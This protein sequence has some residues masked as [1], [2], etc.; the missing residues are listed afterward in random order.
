[1]TYI[2]DNMPIERAYELGYFH[3]KFDSKAISEDVNFTYG[4]Y[5]LT[6]DTKILYY[7]GAFGVF[8]DGH[9]SAIV[10]AINFY[11][12]SGIKVL[13]VI[14]PCNSD[15]TASKYGAYSPMAANKQ[16]YE[17]IK[18]CLPEGV[19]IDLNCMLNYIEDVN[20]TELLLRFVKV[21]GFEMKDFTHK[22]TLVFGKD[23]QQWEALKNYSDEIDTFAAPD[24]TGMSSSNL[25]AI[26]YPNDIVK[27][28]CV[29]R[30]HTI[31]EYRH[32]RSC[33]ADQYKTI[34]PQLISQ[35]IA[36]VDHF[37]NHHKTN[38]PVVTI[39]KDYAGILPYYPLS[40]TWINPFEQGGFSD[41]KLKHLRKSL[42]VD[43]DTFTGSTRDYILSLGHEFVAM[44]EYSCE[45][46]EVL[47]IDDFRKD[48]FRYPFTDISYRCS[49]QAFDSKMHHK[50]NNFKFLMKGK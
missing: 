45:E 10:S 41:N 17:S 18:N 14:A 21:H 49:M 38:L 5:S 13:A 23:R 25:K 27:K 1:M 24:V 22:P 44:N 35:E 47:D 40:R 29:L 26:L 37:V 12:S 15:Y 9:V 43:S 32:F 39:C 20:F 50:F 16:R 31:E 48:D 30:C 46:T 11:K 42:V 6:K 19:I 4:K 2:Y 3:G 36:D 8:H 7:P 34:K 33:F 28:D